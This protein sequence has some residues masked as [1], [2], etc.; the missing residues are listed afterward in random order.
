MLIDMGTLLFII[1]LLANAFLLTMLALGQV[2]ENFRFWPPPKRDSWQYRSLW[3]AIRVLVLCIGLISWF[4][5]SSLDIPHWLR[6]YVALP[7]FVIAAVL[8]TVAFLQLGWRN[9]HGEAAGFIETGLYKY[10]RNPQYVFYS[11]ACIFLG[12]SV[13]SSKAIVLLVLA[14]FCYLSAP[15]PEERWLAKQYGEKYL[16]YKRRVPRYLGLPS[17]K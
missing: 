5:W 16:A 9:S 7:M 2:K 13:A 1:G 14:I 11:I 10:S 4:E 6:F 12:V 8:G 3:G 17:A 15:F